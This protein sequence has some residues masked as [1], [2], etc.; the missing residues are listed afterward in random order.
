M[1]AVSTPELEELEARSR[2]FPFAALEGCM[3]GL[4]LFSSAF[5][6]VNDA[7]HFA[8]SGVQ[9]TCVDR[10][11][12]RLR[13]MKRLYPESWTFIQAD[14]WTFAEAMRDEELAWDAVC[15]DPFTGDAMDRAWE[16]L[17]LWRSLSRR[18]LI[19]GADRA[20]LQRP[21]AGWVSVVDRAPGV[22]WVV[23]HHP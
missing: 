18:V 12:E 13:E 8:M 20:A 6:G 5:L 9:T 21:W 3:D 22:Y 10:D 19:M 4:C 15:V 1:D 16:T 14:A 23:F 7:V 17:E 2:P 11:G